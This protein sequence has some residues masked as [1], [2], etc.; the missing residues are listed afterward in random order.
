MPT[1]RSADMGNKYSYLGFYNDSGVFTGGTPTLPTAGTSSGMMRLLGIKE[2]PITTPD[3]E[4]IQATGDDSII[5]DWDL[6]STESRRYIA[7]MATEDL[8]LI[9]Y[10]SGVPVETIANGNWVSEDIVDAPE[11]NCCL[12]HQSRAKK[13]DDTNSGQK[14]WKG[15]VVPI[16]TVKWLGRDSFNER[17]VGTFRMSITPQ[18][19]SYD[20][21]GFT[22]SPL[23]FFRKFRSDYPYFM[24]AIVGD[25]TAT[26]FNV[27]VPPVSVA[28]T[29]VTWDKVARTVAS[30]NN[31]TV[32]HSV[33]LSAPAPLNKAGVILQQFR[34]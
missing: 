12:I 8:Y 32:P 2:V 10:L 14:A 27:D 22:V 17:A 5:A 28:G 15:I 4:T 19:S 3:S 33:T 29:L 9:S 16:A 18:L 23:A 1:L 24:S 6:G 11:L 25:G 26:S 30:V 31:T 20:A 7:T 21:W 34:G 13:L